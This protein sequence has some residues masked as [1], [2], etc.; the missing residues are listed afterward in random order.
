MTKIVLLDR[1]GIIN[2]DSFHYIRSI[3]EFIFLPKSVDAIVR[4]TH[5]G[6]RIGVATNQ[7]GVARGYYTEQTLT[8]IHE[9][10]LSGVRKAGGDIAAIEYCMHLP[11]EG[12]S[13]RKPNPGM[14]FSLAKRLNCTLSN[15]P[16]IGDKI[17]DIQAAERAGAKPIIVLSEMTDTLQL[18]SYSHVPIFNSLY[19]CVE[20]LLNK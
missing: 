2:Q 4:L 12:C 5:A 19:E 10:M 1:D 9:K 6:Y 16:F 20:S 13:C 17:S 8:A 11:E 15:V 18:Q 3:D 7:S 14:L